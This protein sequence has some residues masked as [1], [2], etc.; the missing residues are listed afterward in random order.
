ME[1]VGAP[2]VSGCYG[3][4]QQNAPS[5][6]AMPFA[7]EHNPTAFPTPI[8]RYADTPIRSFELSIPRV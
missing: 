6:P 5:S 8:R 7:R 3:P 4:K 2:K 1:R